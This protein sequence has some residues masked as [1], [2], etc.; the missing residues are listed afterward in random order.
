[1]PDPEL[2]LDAIFCGAIELRSADARA[3]YLAEACGGQDDLRRQVESLVAAHFRAGSFLAPPSAAPA[4]TVGYP[5]P[6]AAGTQIGPYKLLEQIGEGGMG[7]VYV[8]EQT[9]PVKRRVA[10]KVIKPGMDTKEVVARF[11]AERQ[12]LAL[13][14]HPN[15]AKVFDGGVHDGRPYFV[16]E[17][18]RGLP[19][20]D[21]CDRANLPTRDRL[22]LFATVCRAVQHAHQKGVIHR[23]L[24]PSNIL[25]TLHDGKPVPKVIDFGV[26][27][28]VNQALTE[29]SLYTRFAQMVGTPLY[30][31][32]EQ[33]ELSGLDVDTRS[34]VYSLGVLLYELLTGTTPFDADTL[35]KAGLDEMRRIIRE[36]EPQRPSQRVSTLGEPERSGV[37]GKRGL[38]E[39]RL[40][41]LLR[42]D[43]DWVAMRA[44][45]KDRNRR[46]DTAGAFAA[47]VERYLADELVDARPPTAWYR[48]RKSARRN[49]GLLVTAGLVAAALLAGTGVSVWQAIRATDAQRQAEADRDRAEVAEKRTAEEAAI[50]RTVSDFLQHDL[51]D[52]VDSDPKFRD[53]GDGNTKLTV[54]ESLDRAAAKIGT[55]FQDQPL[56][57]AAI[58]MAIG[59]AYRAV[60]NNTL[61]VPH[62]KRALALRR[63]HL[64]PAHQDTLESMHHLATAYS[65]MMRSDEA[66]ALRQ[67]V[68]NIR[69]AT[70]GPDDL[71][72][73]SC[74]S[75]L[76]GAYQLGKQ[77]ESCIPLYQQVLE[78]AR[79]TC[80]PTHPFTLNTTHSLAMCYQMVNRPADSLDLYETLLD[81]LK[82]KNGPDHESTVWP[83]M[84]YAQACQRAGDLDRADQLLREALA[85]HQKQEPSRR[86]RAAR[87]RITG[88]MALSLCLRKKYAEAEPLVRE[89]LTVF[90][91]E[92]S[93]DPA[94]FYWVSLLGE[95]LAGQQKYA[96]AE[97][98]LLRGYEGMKAGEASHYVADLRI[99]EAGERVARFYE[100]TGQPE[101]AREWRAKLSPPAHQK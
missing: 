60:N 54:K 66:I 59:K 99:R 92:T 75:E 65:W 98:L 64:D 14:D 89:T 4:D 81:A 73:L 55:R 37:S 52:Q 70:H 7:V 22:T 38:D 2:T 6:D 12:A 27:K 100:A 57:E 29:R 9:A 69:K 50:A 44:L 23:D 11:E 101:K 40:S 97:P 43:L 86:W 63:I 15:I 36:E 62:L 51:L 61:A 49:R 34:D 45:E 39:R 24:K 47:D 71:V 91:R 20:T 21:Y 87:A 17:L 46:Y 25:V 78:K 77:F 83:R 94:R 96:D 72:T 28:A 30:M 1:M 10:L 58:R 67:E 41:R 84:T 33:A 56:V 26:A 5:F 32:P 3:A 42:G 76:A 13:M 53:E 31:S 74:M 88:W 93:E 16:M 19:I 35:R 68:L 95:T 90:E 48:L 82:S 80:G 8:A 18:V 79:S 85:I